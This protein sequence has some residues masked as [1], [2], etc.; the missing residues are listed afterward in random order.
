MWGD[1]VPRTR[2]LQSR[3]T[4]LKEELETLRG[5]YERVAREKVRERKSHPHRLLIFIRFLLFI[6]LPVFPCASKKCT[7]P[8]THKQLCF[9]AYL[10]THFAVRLQPRDAR[11]LRS[12]GFGRVQKFF[13]DG[14]LAAFFILQISFCAFCCIH[15]NNEFFCNARYFYPMKSN[16]LVSTVPRF[17]AHSPTGRRDPRRR[18]ADRRSPSGS[19]RG[20]HATSPSLLTVFSSTISQ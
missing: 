12:S 13:V 11:S 18:H 14:F 2:D 1:V 5:S 4:V 3:V 9:A 17:S 6:G 16:H 8:P 20:S 15:H 10:L 19:S 7:H